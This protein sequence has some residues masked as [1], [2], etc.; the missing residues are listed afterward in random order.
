MV[1]QQRQS[2]E[3]RA[4]DELRRE[5]SDV[6]AGLR[7]LADFLEDHP[8]VDVRYA[9]WSFNLFPED[10][11]EIGRGGY[12]RLEKKVKGDWYCLIKH[13]GKHVTLEFN[14]SRELVCERVKVGEKIIPAEPERFIPEQVIPA[15]PERVEE[16][17][18]WKCPPVLAKPADP[19]AEA[20]EDFARHKTPSIRQANPTDPSDL[21]TVD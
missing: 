18:E 11:A 2:T 7:D 13:F 8:E 4:R 3:D 10:L 5:A 6:A 17:Y 14:K 21:L 1:T 9:G 20:V 19:V 12:G 16:V 15:K